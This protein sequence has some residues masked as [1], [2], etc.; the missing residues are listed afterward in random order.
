MHEIL[1]MH[2]Y[3]KEWNARGRAGLLK[4]WHV[5]EATKIY[6]SLQIASFGLFLAF[7]NNAKKPGMSS[8]CIGT[9][10]KTEH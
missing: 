8:L 1:K 10:K 6:G 3:K 2:F 9:V 7:L 4:E 5:K